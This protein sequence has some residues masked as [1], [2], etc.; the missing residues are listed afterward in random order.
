MEKIRLRDIADALG[1]SVATVSNVLN[2]K[3]SKVSRP[4]GPGSWKPWKDPDICQSAQKCFL[5]GTRPAWWGWW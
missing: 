1:L 3:D 5:A 4:P 2:G